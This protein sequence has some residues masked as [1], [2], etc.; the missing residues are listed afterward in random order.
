MTLA[1]RLRQ[2]RLVLGYTLDEV[3]ELIQRRGHTVSKASISKY[4]LGKSVPNATNLWHLSCVLEAPP[5]Y[6]LR[7]PRYEVSWI[8]FRKT[9]RLSK[10]NEERIRYFAKEQIE[11]RFFLNE[12]LGI[13]LESPGMKKFAVSAYEDVEKISRSLRREWR[14]DTWPIESLSRTLE[15]ESMFLVEIE[16]MNDF[17]GLSGWID[18]TYPL[19]ITTGGVPIDRKRMNIAHEFA[20]TVLDVKNDQ[21]NTEKLAF[22]FAAALL[23]PE[24]AMKETLGTRRRTVDIGELVL[25]KEEY[26]ISI[27]A[28]IRRCFDLG[29][30][31]ESEYRKMNIHMRSKGLH[32]NEPGICTNKEKPSMIKSR[33]LRAIAEGYTTESELLSRFPTLSSEIDVM[34]ELGSWQDKT[35]QEKSTI[36]REAAERMETEYTPGGALSNFEIVDTIHDYE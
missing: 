31:S 34:H 10:T 5:E 29:I 22:R 14:I 19:I 16:E 35:M 8:A 33:L 24:Q 12:V 15:E 17:D 13:R 2:R 3:K 18:D 30:L 25:L 21:L 28:L 7:E 26:G 9:T 1:Q 6:F 11:A 20:H 32:V 36:L 27:Q 23:M 4:E